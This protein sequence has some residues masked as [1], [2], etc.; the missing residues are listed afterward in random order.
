MEGRVSTIVLFCF[1]RRTKIGEGVVSLGCTRG[2]L[3]EGLR[4]N[5]LFFSILIK[6]SRLGELSL[7][8]Y[9]FC[10]DYVFVLFSIWFCMMLISYYRHC[11]WEL[12]KLILCIKFWGDLYELDEGFRTV[13]VNYGQTFRFGDSNL[14]KTYSCGCL[15]KWS[16][17]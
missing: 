11:D 4:R 7:Y 16:A 6:N 5:I 13:L 8:A 3:G 12:E 17:W 15:I 2:E 10:C 1:E 14:F 9:E